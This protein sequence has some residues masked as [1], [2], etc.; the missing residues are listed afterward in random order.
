MRGDVHDEIVRKVYE[1]D[2]D[3]LILGSRNMGAIKRLVFIFF[4]SY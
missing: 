1:L 4:T 2:A 3:V